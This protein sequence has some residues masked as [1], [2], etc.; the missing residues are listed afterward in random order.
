MAEQSED[1]VFLDAV[2]DSSE[3]R[4]LEFK[5]AATQYSFDK[6][7]AYCAAL[8]NEGGGSLILGISDMKPRD[9]VGT[10]A[11]SN[12]QKLEF[13]LHHKLRLRILVR[14]LYY[15][16]KRVLVVTVPPRPPGT[17]IEVDGKYLMRQGESLVPMTADALRSIFAEAQGTYLERPASEAMSV[18]SALSL[19][20]P[21]I[22]FQL[23]KQA[24]P[25]SPASIVSKFILEGLLVPA[26]GSMVQITNLGA[27]L[28]ARDLDDFRDLRFHRVRILKYSGKNN[29]H[30]VV[31]RLETRGYAVAFTSTLELVR[32]HVPVNERIVDSLRE[33]IPLYP[34]VAIREFYANALI[35]QDFEQSGSSVTVEIFS[36]R[37]VINNPGTPV[38]DVRRFV[39]ETKSR[40]QVLA[41]L[42]RRLGICEIRGSGI[43]RVLEQLEFY[44]QP[45]PLFEARS[46]STVVTLIAH[47]RFED[48]SIDER[49]WAAFLHC[50]LKYVALDKL[51]NSSLRARFGLSS[52]KSTLV[53]QAIAR[54]VSQGLIRPDADP[55]SGR[56][57]ARYVPTFA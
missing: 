15:E 13:D 53:S 7:L 28:F 32:S 20:E 46:Q 23:Q 41:D 36:D 51:T 29:V 42:M 19:L 16:T 31:D 52:D 35:H 2:M 3:N 5:A 4:S 24:L 22:Y 39:D 40:N 18:E 17:P 12:V 26:E 56:K 37:L 34:E 25:T 27:I 1:E 8:A 10:A 54:A 49:A 38:I 55:A 30:T 43:D 14:E 48:M 45:A 57:S 11:F 21:A 33:E 50:C 9:I 6:A 44:Q 47:R